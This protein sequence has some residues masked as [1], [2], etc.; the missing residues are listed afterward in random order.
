M[1]IMPHP[2]QL[3]QKKTQ[4]STTDTIAAHP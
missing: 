3:N 1:A 4:D 2:M